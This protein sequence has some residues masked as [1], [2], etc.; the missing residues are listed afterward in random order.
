MRG[1]VTYLAVLA[2]V[3]ATAALAQSTKSV[4]S[5]VYTAPQATSGEAI[6]FAACAKCHG[7]DL[8]GLERAPAL[9]GGTFGQRWDGAT[10]KKL[11]E[12]LEQMPPD[13][14]AARLTPQK[15]ADVLAFLLSANDSACGHGNARPGQGRTRGDHLYEPAAEVTAAVASRRGLM[16]HRT[17]SRAGVVAGLGLLCM[18]FGQAGRATGPKRAPAA[19]AHVEWRT[20]GADFASTRYSSL[21]QIDQSN[22]SRLKIAWRLK[23]TEFGP[24]PDTLYSATPLFVD[25]VLYTTAGTARTVVALNP[26]TGEV[27]W[28]H[29]EDEGPRGQNAARGGAGRGVAYWA[30][31]D[32]ADRRI[33]YVTPGYRMIALDARTGAPVSSFGQNGV[34]DLKAR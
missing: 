4:W 34:V 33:V 9:A 32:G 19:A 11:F 5:G 20:Y 24:R 1:R 26:Q 8:G 16:Q 31:P 25:N 13:D 10:L 22:F 28:T 29:V 27:L 3:L 2:A 6:Y 12:R 23:T 17:L 14:P 30:S 21:D 15:Y 7:D 18:A